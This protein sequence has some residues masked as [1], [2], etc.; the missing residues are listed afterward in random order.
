[1][2][3]VWEKRSQGVSKLERRRSSGSELQLC[4]RGLIESSAKDRLSDILQNPRKDNLV[5]QGILERLKQGPV[6]G[7]GGYIIELERRGYVIAAAF[8]PEVAVKHPGAIRSLHSEFLNAGA[9][10]VQVMAFY[11]SR[12]KLA[13]V[14]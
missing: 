1:M 13:T 9:E 7:D 4:R 8:T 6:L 3:C 2:V 5:K 10:V 11:G 14:G 12:E